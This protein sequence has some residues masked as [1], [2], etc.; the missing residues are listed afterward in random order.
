MFKAIFFDADNTLFDNLECAKFYLEKTCEKMGI[1]YSQEF[2]DT[3][4]KINSPLW[5]RVEEGKLL[6]SEVKNI[7]FKSVFEELKIEGVDP[8]K[9]ESTLLEMIAQSHALIEGVAEVLSLLAP[10]YAI[11]MA[12]NSRHGQQQNRCRLAGIDKYFTGYF[13]SDE[14]GAPKPNSEFFQRA[15]ATLDGVKPHEVLMVGDSLRADIAGGKAFGL[16]TCWFDYFK[17]GGDFPSVKPDFTIREFSDL[18]AL[19]LPDGEFFASDEKTLQKSD[20]FLKKNL[21][22]YEELS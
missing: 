12:S 15:F 21:K 2:Y 17:D 19:L 10:H 14:L 9:T 7:R 16:T 11:Y 5:K 20:E 18:L 4:F 22:A 6:R 13:I 8:L 1:P 3:Y